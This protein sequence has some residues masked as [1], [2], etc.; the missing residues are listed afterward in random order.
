[1]YYQLL[2]TFHRS[3]TLKAVLNQEMAWFDREEQSVG[4]LSARLA[5]D[6]ASLQA[7]M[8]FSL[9]GI[10]QS[11]SNFIMGVSIAMYYSW[12]LA[13]VCLTMVPIIVGSV[14]FEAK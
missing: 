3:R 7:S 5:G 12:R 13:L 2:I 6:S 11:I 8:G 14:V 1:M 9:S 10:I 4:A